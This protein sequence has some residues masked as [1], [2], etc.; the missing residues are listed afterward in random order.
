MMVPAG[1]GDVRIG[2]HRTLVTLPLSR[3]DAVGAAALSVASAAVAWLAAPYMFAMWRWAFVTGS[4]VLDLGGRVE[5]VPST[6]FSTPIPVLAVEAARPGRTALI[7][8]AVVVVAL[9]VIAQ[10]FA[11]TALPA[12][13]FSR[14]V[15]LVLASAVAVFGLG[16][17]NTLDLSEYS[18][19][20]LRVSAGIW[21]LIPLVYGLTLFL[22]DIGWTRKAALIAIA[23]A[24]LA[25]FIPLQQL[26]AIYVVRHLTLL[27]LPLVFVF[28]SIVPQVAVL[29]ALYAW[30]ASWPERGR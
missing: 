12:T 19:A 1:N 17:S 22:L 14:A 24:H 29:I 20:M 10:R 21:M 26:V 8:A 2:P 6:I 18:R 13:Y 3:A 15:A 30:G 4:G 9:I 7:V 28:G 25:L 16:G 5:S 27:A 11:A 23:M